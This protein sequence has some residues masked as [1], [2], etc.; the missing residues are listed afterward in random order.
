MPPL[1]LGAYLATPTTIQQRDLNND[2]RPDLMIR[3]NVGGIHILLAQEDGTYRRLGDVEKEWKEQASSQ[4][5]QAVDSI[6]KKIEEIRAK[7]K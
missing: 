4:S 1:F 2:G 3:N 5:Q 7:A 6:D